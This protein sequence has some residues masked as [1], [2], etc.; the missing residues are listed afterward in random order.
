MVFL[1]DLLEP[2]LVDFTFKVLLAARFEFGSA[3]TIM[4]EG[5]TIGRGIRFVGTVADTRVVVVFGG[6]LLPTFATSLAI[7]PFYPRPA[8]A[9]IATGVGGRMGTWWARTMWAT[10]LGLEGTVFSRRGHPLFGF[11]KGGV[12]RDELGG[13]YV[14]LGQRIDSSV[15]L[16]LNNTQ[17]SSNSRLE[18]L[19]VV[20]GAIGHAREIHLNDGGGKIT[21]IERAGCRNEAGRLD[22][23]IVARSVTEAVLG[24]V[25]LEE[26]LV[27]I[28]VGVKFVNEQLP[29]DNATL[30]CFRKA[31]KA[32]FDGHKEIC[33][34]G[35]SQL[36]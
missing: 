34:N 8:R 2:R 12:F 4:T 17:E 10:L 20:V 23:H 5:R 33:F 19:A 22:G 29:K 15:V 31:I 35:V 9:I 1:F 13:D 36:L 21:T 25:C 11:E 18:R 14:E 6:M 30:L 7:K 24:Q 16:N 27:F 28:A 32:L 26:F 3:R